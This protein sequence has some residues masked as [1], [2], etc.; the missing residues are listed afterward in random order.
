MDFSLEVSPLMV[1]KPRSRA[2]Q[3]SQSGGP[4]SI[5]LAILSNALQ[6]DRRIG[7]EAGRPRV[8]RHSS[9]DTDLIEPREDA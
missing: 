6:S 9:V 4:N 8:R 2:S 1:A 7:K 5:F 3:D